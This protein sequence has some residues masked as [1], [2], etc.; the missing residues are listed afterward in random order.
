MSTRKTSLFKTIGNYFLLLISS[1]AIV[2]SIKTSDQIYYP[3]FLAGLSGLLIGLIAP[4]KGW[5]LALIQN[6]MI[7]LIYLLLGTGNLKGSRFEL[8]MFSM[9]GAILFV[10]F[11]SLCTAFIKR[12]K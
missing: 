9:V 11:I 3:T 8:E 10:F 1:V 12:A 5:F 7:T 6:A 4:Q 2:Y